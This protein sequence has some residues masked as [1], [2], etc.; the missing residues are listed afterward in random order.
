MTLAIMLLL[1]YIPFFGWMGLQAYQDWKQLKK[2]R[3]Y[4]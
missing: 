1:A 2:E 3:K 4:K